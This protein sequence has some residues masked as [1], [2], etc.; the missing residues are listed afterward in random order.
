MI[1]CRRPMVLLT[2]C[3][4]LVLCVISVLTFHATFP[5]LSIKYQPLAS[6]VGR[7]NKH[8]KSSTLSRHVHVAVGGP[9]TS[10]K[11]LSII[12]NNH[13]V[14][15]TAKHKLKSLAIFS[16]CFYSMLQFLGYSFENSVP[17]R[18]SFNASFPFRIFINSRS[19]GKEGH[20]LLNNLRLLM[21]HDRVCDLSVDSPELA[22]SDMH[23]ELVAAGNVGSMQPTA[24]CC[25]GDGTVKWIMDVAKANSV[26]HNTTFAVIP[27]GTGND[28]FNHIM[29]NYVKDSFVNRVVRALLSPFNLV[30]DP[31]ISLQLFSAPHQLCSF[32]RWKL[33]IERLKTTNESSIGG[34]DLHNS[35]ALSTE[36]RQRIKTLLKSVQSKF[37]K[38]AVLVFPSK[39]AV[40]VNQFNNYFGIGI[41]GDIASTFHLMRKHQ[42]HLFFHR[43]VNKLWYGIV[44]IYR[45]FTARYKSISENIELFCDGELVDTSDKRL[46]GIILTNINSYAGGSKLWHVQ[47]PWQELSSEDGIIEV[48]STDDYCFL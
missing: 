41:D 26:S 11:V 6:K 37:L 43:I 25:G 16:L 45:A 4:V 2:R 3:I 29:E 23:Q 47:T 34:A 48:C 40:N 24:F 14:S 27:M 36:H 39:P 42:P 5:R 17:M 18:K 8:F 20:S 30:N 21:P 15:D 46:A 33:T 22:L 19:G 10:T 38:T 1:G 7:D 13:M 35:S 12:S 31:A 28:L 9:T 32:N 44:W